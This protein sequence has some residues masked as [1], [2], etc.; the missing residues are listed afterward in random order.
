MRRFMA[1]V[2]RAERAWRRGLTYA[3]MVLATVAAMLCVLGAIG[4]ATGLLP[5]HIGHESI[6]GAAGALI[7]MAA[8]AVGFVAV[9]LALAIVL[10]VVYALGFVLAGVFIIVAIAVAISLF[11]VMAPFILLALGIAWLVRRMQRKPSTLESTHAHRDP[12]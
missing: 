10:A 5:L 7:G 1:R 9:V 3:F 6:G 12:G 11:P 4:V 8:F 2:G